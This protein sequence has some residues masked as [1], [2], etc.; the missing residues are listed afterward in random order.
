MQINSP[1]KQA[2][3]VGTSAHAGVSKLFEK[4]R[5]VE[6][7][8]DYRPLVHKNI[9]RKEFKGRALDSVTTQ[10]DY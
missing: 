8:T 1:Y 6:N 3:H 2:P 9:N 5:K 10:I 4:T 7:Q